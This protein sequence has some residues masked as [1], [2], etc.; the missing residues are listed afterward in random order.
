MGPAGVIPTGNEELDLKLA[1]GLPHPSLIIIEGEHGTGKTALAQQFLLGAL[2][3]GLKVTVFTSETTSRDYVYKMRSSGFDAI[4]Y[5]IMGKLKVYTISYPG[6]LTF[7]VGELITLR[8]AIYIRSRIN[9]YD[10][11]VIDNLS[12]IASVVSKE[13]LQRL[14]VVIRKAVDSGKSFIITVHPNALPPDISTKVKSI[15]DGYFRLLSATVG[16]RRVK[17]LNIV[18]LRGAPPGLD[19]SITFDVD[20]AFGIKLIPIVISKT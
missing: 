3:S 9:E 17:I 11:L 20:P 15:A 16:G 2:K 5:Y 8:L 13:S 1:G 19:T 14:I 4:D 6:R 7:E 18:K 10:L 12:Y